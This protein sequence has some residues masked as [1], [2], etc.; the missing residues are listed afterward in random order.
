VWTRTVPP[1]TT[2]G[3][4]APAVDGSWLL[5][6]VERDRWVRIVDASTARA[7]LAAHVLAR[8]QLG[9][10][11][12]RDPASL[13]FDRTCSEC[14]APHGPPRLIDDPAV[15]VSLSRTAGR[16]AVAITRGGP[17]GVDVERCAAVLFAGFADVA[18]HPAERPPAEASGG[19]A[20]PA[21]AWVRK[22]AALKALGVGLRVDP[23]T[24]RT[25]PVGVPARVVAGRPCVAVVDVVVDGT[26][27]NPDDTHVGAVAVVGAARV[28][29]RHH[30]EA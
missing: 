14:G 26:G 19:A 10:L 22:E 30:P 8:T 17:V 9:R 11:L 6:A 12:G 23:A 7:Y 20:A 16:V 27:V 21:T 29:V 15:H 24:L 28:H 13:R 25:P 3:E 2:P 18:L 4:Q 5:D 1:A